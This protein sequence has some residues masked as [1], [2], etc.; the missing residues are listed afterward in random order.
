MLLVDT[1][2]KQNEHISLPIIE[3]PGLRLNDS[4]EHVILTNI[5]KYYEYFLKMNEANKYNRETLNAEQEL[6]EAEEY[7]Q[8][9]IQKILE[10]IKID[11]IFNAGWTRLEERKALLR[12]IVDSILERFR[13]D[14]SIL[15]KFIRNNLEL[16][17]QKTVKHPLAFNINHVYEK[18]IVINREMHK[19]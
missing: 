5:A 2:L 13:E 1:L 10:F 18:L 16:V 6:E 15:G 9:T 14:L 11:F 12:P 17:L 19:I 7:C 8:L 3:Y 4:K